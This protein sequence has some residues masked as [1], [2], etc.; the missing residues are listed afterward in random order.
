[1]NIYTISILLFIL[2][3][4][5]VFLAL[6]YFSLQ[7]KYH[8]LQTTNATLEV[9]IEEQNRYN[10]EKSL[11]LESHKA[12]LKE[13]FEK[14]A[15]RVLQ[16]NAQTFTSLSTQNLDKLINPLHQQLYEFKQQVADVY[17]K[18]SQERAVLQHEI[19]TLKTLNQQIS[20]DAIN[21]TKALKGENKK[22][23]IW[24]E[25]V[26]TRILENSGLREGSEF[27]R[28]VTCYTEENKS[29]RPDVIVKL[30][31]DKD[32]IIDAK[33]SLIAYE[34]Y[35]N[36]QDSKAKA[37]H[38]KAH[39]DSIKKHI[40]SLS[41]KNYENLKGLN[42]LDFIF[43]FMP[44]EGALATALEHNTTLYDYALNQKIILVS[45]TTLL[46]AMRTIE[47]IWRQEKQNKNAKDIAKRAGAMYDKFVGFSEDMVK[48]SKQLDTVQQSFLSAKTK[49]SHGRG[50]LVDQAQNLKELGAQSSK[51]LS[52]QL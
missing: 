35:I 20:Q 26:L 34:R 22:Q 42:T 3:L 14:V 18:E 47:N 45:P 28:E 46:V 40:N 11:L 32:I 23:G 48:I 38:L 44:I 2:F 9:K 39:I 15:N 29:F 12:E 27:Q 33:T 51:K 24:G 10:Q 8:Q 19:G 6:Q 52:K 16:N 36:T 30:P 37:E 4:I 21:L 43:M 50:N 31:N 13:E 5:I 7:E 41:E 25:M 17:T 49:L 1:M